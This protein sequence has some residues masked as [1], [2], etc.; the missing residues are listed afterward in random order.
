LADVSARVVSGG[1]QTTVQDLGRARTQRHAVPVGGAMDTMA[2][3]LANLVVGNEEHAA[4]LE[5]TLIGPAIQFGAATLIAVGGADLTAT[6]DSTPI[7]RW[8]AVLAPAGCTLR[9][10]RPENGCRAYVA[11]AGGV[12]VPQV[13]G[14]RATYLRGAFGGIDGRALRDGD[15][16]RLGEASALSR[17]IA[18]S[19]RDDAGG[20][21]LARW[22]AGATLRPPYSAEPIVRLM[23]GAHT[24]ALDTESRTALFG[25]RF[26]V[27]ASSD[28]MG[29]R[30]EGP[31]LRL[32]E[33][34]EML[35]EGVTFGTVQLP[36][37]GAPIVLMA[38]GQTTGGYP[39]VGEVA[40]VDLPLMAQLKP[41]DH[42]QFAPVSLEEAQ[43]LYL[44]RENELAQ[45]KV[46]LA[47]RFSRGGGGDAT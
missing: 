26:R 37:G 40:S 7:G 35:S 17:R 22:Y 23:P 42:V 9:F 31:H 47:F 6:V 19:L 30:L 18:A 41:G 27:S 39:R 29:Y 36:P 8:R 21:A 1:L 33:R 12:D 32:R 13:F 2:L 45:M 24:D 16:I 11:L 44:E 28:R 3:R 38:D 43:R 15:E 5:A 34:V 46:G 10:G 25:D 14:S 4:G 20:P